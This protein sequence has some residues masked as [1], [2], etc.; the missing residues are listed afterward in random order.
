MSPH[1]GFYGASG[2]VVRTISPNVCVLM[3][4]GYDRHRRPRRRHTLG[5]SLGVTTA[6]VGTVA[7][8]GCP[9]RNIG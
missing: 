7:I 6:P 3:T 8:G 9:E 4:N 1:T 5:K 2:A